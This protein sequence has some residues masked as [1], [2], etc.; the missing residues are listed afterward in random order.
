MATDPS[1]AALEVIRDDEAA[2][3]AARIAAARA[4]LEMEV[5]LGRLATGPA[6]GELHQLSRQELERLAAAVALE[7]AAANPTILGPVVLP[8]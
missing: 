5:K 7:R 8:S 2:A 1:I 4:L 6:R 3:P